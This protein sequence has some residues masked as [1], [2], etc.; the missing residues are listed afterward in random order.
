MADVYTE[1]LDQ[2]RDMTNWLIHSTRP[3]GKRS[4]LQVLAK[5]LTEGILRPDFSELGRG[6]TVK[7]RR[8]I[9]GPDPAVCFTEQ[10]LVDFATYA[11]VRPGAIHPYGVLIHKHDV[12]A[13]GGL[14]VIY[15]LE[16]VLYEKD[17][18]HD[19][20]LDCRILTQDCL[21]YHEQYRYVTFAPQ[22][23]IDWSHEREWRWS[24]AAEYGRGTGLFY[25]CGNEWVRIKG[26][27]QDRVHAFVK[28]EA[29]AQW[30]ITELR[31]AQT[32]N[33]L[34]TGRQWHRDEYVQVWSKAIQDVTV[35][36]LDTVVAAGYSRFDDVREKKREGV[37]YHR[38]FPF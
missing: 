7:D 28:T 35:I 25:L 8:T 21:P 23:G 4:A 2:R 12:Y 14:P 1:L 36:A 11:R 30:L 19:F 16:N 37:D 20:D 18:N 10:P 31:R 29:D 13:A 33:E 34:G 5:I 26:E 24:A 6:F 9:Y 3:A 15:G 27:Y 32:A 17:N 22:N 38:I